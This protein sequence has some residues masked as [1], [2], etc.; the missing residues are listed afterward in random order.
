MLVVFRRI[1]GF[2]V[3]CLFDGTSP[4]VDISNHRSAPVVG[5]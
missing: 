3:R 5:I 4:A 1:T 2:T